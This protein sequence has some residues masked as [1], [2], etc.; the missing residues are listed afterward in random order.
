M[1]KALSTFV[2]SWFIVPMSTK[3]DN[4][5][6]FLLSED[7]KKTSTEE[8]KRGL[9]NVEHVLK[10]IKSDLKWQT[11]RSAEKAKK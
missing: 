11:W 6:N 10:T 5:F 3:V 9:A 8:K 4:T 2:D 7:F 1:L